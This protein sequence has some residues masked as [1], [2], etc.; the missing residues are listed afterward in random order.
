MPAIFSISAAY[1]SV[2]ALT[3]VI[4][5]RLSCICTDLSRKSIKPFADFCRSWKKSIAFCEPSS[6]SERRMSR[7]PISMPRSDPLA[8]DA[9]WEMLACVVVSLTAPCTLVFPIITVVI[10]PAI[11]RMPRA[12]VMMSFVPMLRLLNRNMF[13]SFGPG[14]RVPDCE[15]KVI[16]WPISA[17]RGRY[18]RSQAAATDLGSA[19]AESAVTN[20]SARRLGRSTS[21]IMVPSMVT[22]PD[23]KSMREERAICGTG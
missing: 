6:E 1:L 14:R 20:C 17:S 4:R 10:I 16:E 7:R 19:F 21:A 9:A 3:F 5:S 23:R 12:D 13:L 2:S 18:R 11:S 8:S 15:I 22:S